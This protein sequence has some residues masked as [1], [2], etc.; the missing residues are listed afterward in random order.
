LPRVGNTEPLGLTS[1]APISSSLVR[2]FGKNEEFEGL[3]L[4][5]DGRLAGDVSPSTQLHPT[6]Q[7]GPGI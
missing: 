7:G 3:G 2:T 6:P 5:A 1:S 4:S